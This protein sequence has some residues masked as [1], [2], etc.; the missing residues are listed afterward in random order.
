[1]SNKTKPLTFDEVHEAKKSFNKDN[2][3]WYVIDAVNNLLTQ[4][5]VKDGPIEFT[6]DALISEI[7]S[8]YYDVTNAELFDKNYLD[9]EDLYESYGWKV[10]YNKTPYYESNGKSTFTFTKA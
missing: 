1:M 9:I 3:P 2:I 5:F 6:Q 7:K 10:T 8:I 4:N